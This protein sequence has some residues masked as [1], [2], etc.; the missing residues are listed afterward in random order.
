MSENNY[1]S[2]SAGI[3]IGGSATAGEDLV[4]RDKYELQF[5]SISAEALESLIRSLLVPKPGSF[6]TKET[7]FMRHIEPT[8]QKMEQVHKD[9]ER[10]L[11]AL[12]TEIEKDPIKMPSLLN[13][14]E[15]RSIDYRSERAYLKNIHWEMDAVVS[16][17]SDDSELEKLRELIHEFSSSVIGYFSLQAIDSP[18]THIIFELKILNDSCISIEGQKGIESVKHVLTTKLHGMIFHVFPSRWETITRTYLKLR[19]ICLT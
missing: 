6:L 12:Q 16:Q 9:Y 8:F 4:G 1:I 15:A 18:Y 14:F 2:N 19:G 3:Y 13:W 5:P 11:L 17:I 7:L 10:A